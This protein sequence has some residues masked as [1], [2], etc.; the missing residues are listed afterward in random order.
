LTFATQF[1]TRIHGKP[2]RENGGRHYHA[3]DDK[4]GKLCG[5]ERRMNF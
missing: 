2:M 1:W 4:I 3:P 5:F